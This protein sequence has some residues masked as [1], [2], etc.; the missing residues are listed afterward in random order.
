MR[1]EK[2]VRGCEANG[3]HKACKKAVQAK[4]KANYQKKK[5]GERKVKKEGSVGPVGEVKH[6]V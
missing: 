5:A 2:K 1:R 3:H 4:I 6:K